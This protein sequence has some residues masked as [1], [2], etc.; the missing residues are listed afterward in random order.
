MGDEPDMTWVL[1]AARPDVQGF[2]EKLG[3]VR[4][5]VAMERVRRP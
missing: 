2:Y 4:S 5:S 3:F 1:R